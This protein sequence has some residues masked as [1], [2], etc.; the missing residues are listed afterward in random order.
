[1]KCEAKGIKFVGGVGPY[2]AKI[3]IVGEALGVEEE[4]QEIPF[5]G[6]AGRLLNFIL[7][8]ARVS[9]ED[10]FVTNVVK[11]RPPQN[12]VE[13]LSEIG[14]TVSEFVPLLK[15]ELQEIKPSVVLALG[16]T[17]FEVLTSLKPISKWRGSIVESSLV[18]KLK[19]IG[20]YHPAAV[21]WA[22]YG[23][24]IA[25]ESLKKKAKQIR[26]LIELDVKRMR[27]ES[28]TAEI[29]V[30]K[31]RLFISPSLNEVHA[32]LD[33]LSS[34]LDFDIKKIA[35]DIEVDSSGLI[36]CLGLSCD[37]EYALCIP[38]RKGYSSYWSEGEEDIIWRW[39]EELFHSKHLFIFQNALFDLMW[40]VP[41][42]GYFDVYMDTMWAAQLLYAELPKDL[43]TLASIYTR[44]PYYKDERKVWKDATITEQLWSYNAK[45]AAVTL[46]V[47]LRLEEELDQARQGDFF[48]GFVMQ[49]L[50]VLLKMQMR[51]IRVDQRVRED[52]RRQLMESKSQLEK[53]LGNLNVRSPKQMKQ[54]LYEELKLP[55]QY[56]KKTKQITTD[57]EALLKLR[58]K[59]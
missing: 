9:R 58:K 1:L 4:K 57:K 5:C 3:V 19:V 21:L 15:E 16:E 28:E 7:K 33:G 14:L 46:E 30:P 55:K 25:K 50:P 47:A 17:A 37:P 35:V 29:N 36:S 44:E 56:K 8:R 45:D 42:V 39:L 10:C 31:R 51:G 52:I 48:F 22:F 13:R 20:T 27:E 18:P 49:L 40:L 43:G 34:Y 2:N 32:L 24:E 53:E 23:G 26:V 59:V 6:G 12:K 41:K 54:F 38:F 11:V